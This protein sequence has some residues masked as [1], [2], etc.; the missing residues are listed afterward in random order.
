MTESLAEKTCTPCRGG[1]PPLPR[2]EAL[3]FHAQAPDWELPAASSAHFRNF[4]LVVC[5]ENSIRVDHVSESPNVG[6]E[7]RAVLPLPGPVR[8]AVQVEEPT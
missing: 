8:L 3:R 1:V 5:T 2:D 6:D 4:R 7:D